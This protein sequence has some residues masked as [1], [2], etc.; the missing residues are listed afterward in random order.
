MGWVK[1]IKI[2]LKVFI[3]RKE[4][5]RIQAT[6][7]KPWLSAR[8]RLAEALDPQRFWETGRVICRISYRFAFSHAATK[9]RMKFVEGRRWNPSASRV[10]R[11][12]LTGVSFYYLC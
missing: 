11:T 10:P 1:K 7:G 9:S 3:E 2:G 12:F 8:G 4:V 6:N 5:L